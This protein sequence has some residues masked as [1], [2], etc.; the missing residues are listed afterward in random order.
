MNL[1]SEAIYDPSRLM[2]QFEELSRFLLDTHC[3]WSE[4]PYFHEELSWSARFPDFWKWVEDL[5]D[6]DVD[7]FEHN[8]ENEPKAPEKWLALYRQIQKL[9]RFPRDVKE[10][11]LK[12]GVLWRVP[13]RKSLQIRSFLSTLRPYLGMDLIDWCAGKGHL[14]RSAASLGGGSLLQVEHCEEL[15]REARRLNGRIG[16]DSR[17]ECIDVLL[18]EAEWPEQALLLAMHACG[19]LGDAAI[20]LHR[21]IG[22]VMA[23]APC[24][25]HKIESDHYVPKSVYGK[26]TGLFFDRS[27]LHFSVAFETVASSR[28]RRLRRQEMDY[29][30]AL[31]AARGKWHVASRSCSRSWFQLPFC[32]FAFKMARRDGFELDGDLDEYL[33]EG[34]RRSVRIRARAM[35]RSPFR[36]AIESWLALDRAISLQEMGRQVSIV[37]FCDR[38]ASPRNLLLL[39]RQEP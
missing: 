29:R 11:D 18:Q 22:G 19:D 12:P 3:L 9:T 32:S 21:R 30:C 35:V 17:V 5:S 39:A 26:G 24:C 31:S 20:G 34:R 36:R 1:D 33:K 16:I 25:H 13:Q 2:S 38:L 37:E 10:I 6:S 7:S 27:V 15:C 23:L 4:N 8:P 14:G 28:N